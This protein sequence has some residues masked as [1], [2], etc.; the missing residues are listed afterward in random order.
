M[1][2]PHSVLAALIATI[3]LAGLAGCETDEDILPPPVVHT[4]LE[5]DPLEPVTITE[6]WASDEQML[7]LRPDGSY[8]LYPDRNRYHAPI[9]RGRWSQASYAWLRIEPYDRLRTETRRVSIVKINDV[10]ALQ[11]PDLEPMF[12]IAR[13]PIVLE[14]RVLGWWSGS[15]GELVLQRGRTYRYYPMPDEFGQPARVAGHQGR[16]RIEDERLLFRPDPLGM[17]AFEMTIETDSDAIVI[18]AEEGP[19]ERTDRGPSSP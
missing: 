16:W 3:M 4:P 1:H 17:D 12:S 2:Q 15:V 11:M 9:E 7:R 19:L 5:I 6:W 10:V 14:D 13:P 8:E 18:R